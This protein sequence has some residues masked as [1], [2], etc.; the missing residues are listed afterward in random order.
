MVISDV[1][2]RQER[3]RTR[4]RPSP[5]RSSRISRR[6]SSL[7]T[8]APIMMGFVLLRLTLAELR[9]FDKKKWPNAGRRRG[10]CELRGKNWPGRVDLNGTLTW[11]EGLCIALENGLTCVVASLTLSRRLTKVP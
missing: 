2:K 5:R 9:I 4:T 6:R 1:R 8:G 3:S 10:H 7:G 11:L